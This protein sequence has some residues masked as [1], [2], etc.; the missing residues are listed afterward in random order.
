M[1]SELKRATNAA[2]AGQTGADAAETACEILR[3]VLSNSRSAFA[4]ST[5]VDALSIT[6]EKHLLDK[7]VMLQTM[8]A[9]VR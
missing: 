3:F 9:L 1:C 8:D 2:G 5:L 6:G 7:A 4:T